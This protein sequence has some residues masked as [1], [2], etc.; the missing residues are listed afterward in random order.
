MRTD[1]NIVR[2]TPANMYGGNADAVALGL[3]IAW[4]FPRDH[5]ERNP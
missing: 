4:A 1:E 2:H 5:D 3:R